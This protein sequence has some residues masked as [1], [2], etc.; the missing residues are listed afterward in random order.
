MLWLTG[1]YS[2]GLIRAYQ[3]SMFLPGIPPL[4]VQEHQKDCWRTTQVVQ[5][6]AE[7]AFAIGRTRIINE[8]HSLKTGKREN[9]AG[10]IQIQNTGELQDI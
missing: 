6:L 7:K 10:A 2:S 9:Q 1:Y 4:Q 8:R 5:E 3:F